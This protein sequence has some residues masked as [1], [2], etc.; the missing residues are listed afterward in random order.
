M[1]LLAPF[2]QLPSYASS[3]LLQSKKTQ[4]LTAKRFWSKSET[5]IANGFKWRALGAEELS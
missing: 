2:T 5:V 4:T 1:L 3:L